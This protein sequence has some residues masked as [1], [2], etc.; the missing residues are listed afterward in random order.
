M[1]PSERTTS[2]PGR[3][4]YNYDWIDIVSLEDMHVHSTFCAGKERESDTYA[5]WIEKGMYC[6]LMRYRLIDGLTC[7]RLTL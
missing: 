6:I 2:P 3:V 7:S 5:G 4:G 1:V